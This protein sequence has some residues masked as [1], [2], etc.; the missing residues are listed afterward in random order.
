L[1]SSQGTLFNKE[2]A[3]NMG[4]RKKP[5]PMKFKMENDNDNKD[6]SVAINETD[7]VEV[8]QALADAKSADKRSRFFMAYFF[9]LPM[10]ACISIS[11]LSPSYCSALVSKYRRNPK[12]R[13]HIDKIFDGWPEVYRNVCKMRLFKLQEAEGKAV[14]KYLDNPELLIDKPQLAK[15]IKLAAGAMPTDD[16]PK[17]M[18]INIS[19]M[20]AI[21]G[22]K[23][24]SFPSLKKTEEENE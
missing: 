20:Q 22:E 13:A 2:G 1:A 14:E 16:F 19:N 5:F 9:N 23:F 11:G 18:M 15:Q 21:I 6:L 3:K 7:T 10:E 12:L 8:I 17:P 4:R 24:G